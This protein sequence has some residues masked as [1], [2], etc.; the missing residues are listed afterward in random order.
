VRFVDVDENSKRQLQLWVERRYF[1]P[2]SAAH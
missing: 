2:V 1:Q